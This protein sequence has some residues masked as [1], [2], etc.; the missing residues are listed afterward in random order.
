MHVTFRFPYLSGVLL[1]LVP[2]FAAAE[3]PLP[4]PDPV[5]PA[6]I[7]R[8]L[9]RIQPVRPPHPKT[10]AAKPVR[11]E[12]LAVTEK[13][14]RT[15]PPAPVA[16]VPTAVLGAAAARPPGPGASFSSKDHT[17]VRQFYEAHP[18][19]AKA[20]QWKIGEP[21]PP[22]AALTGVPDDLRAAL[23]VLPRGLQYVQVDGEV[24][25][26]AMQ[27]RVVVDGISRGTR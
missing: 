20:A 19:S 14:V 26:V 12:Q 7:G 6:V 21:I 13:V 11:R 23:S 8:P 16:P 1:L 25:L 18:V 27:S 15:P 22:R 24:V 4:L 10:A 2:P 3:G 9:D 5:A 17:L